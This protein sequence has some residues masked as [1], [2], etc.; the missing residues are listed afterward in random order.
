MFILSISFLCE[1]DVKTRPGFEMGE[2]CLA[3]LFHVL[4]TEG[5]AVMALACVPDQRLA[6]L[7]SDGSYRFLQT[8]E[9]RKTR[10]YHPFQLLCL[11]ILIVSVYSAIFHMRTGF[12]CCQR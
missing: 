9:F 6:L 2:F 3:W 10:V 8:S 4:N 7:Q 12:R 5:V 11:I 1:V